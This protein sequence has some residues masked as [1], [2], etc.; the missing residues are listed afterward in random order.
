M[1]LHVIYLAFPLFCCKKEIDGFILSRRSA[2]EARDQKP[3]YGKRHLDNKKLTRT[4]AAICRCNKYL[5]GT[6]EIIYA[7]NV[8]VTDK[9]PNA[10]SLRIHRAF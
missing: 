1:V 7:K 8:D 2:G 4:T 5:R 3:E 6:M 10:Q 9:G